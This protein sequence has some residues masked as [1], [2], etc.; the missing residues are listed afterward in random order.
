MDPEEFARLLD[1]YDSSFRNIAEGEVV[2]GT[3]LKVELDGA[4]I[5]L[6][7]EDAEDGRG[8]KLAL[9]R[10][11]QRIYEGLIR[12]ALDRDRAFLGCLSLAER[13]HLEALQ[14][15]RE[16]ERLCIKRYACHVTSHAPV[17]SMRELMA[18]PAFHDGERLAPGGEGPGQG[19]VG[20]E[21]VF[22]LEDAAWPI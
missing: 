8:V 22:E 16:I 2:K 5:V 12:A 17:Q 18:E 10:S 3:V 14:G 11:G 19:G 21:Q 4:R 1:S 9:G 20:D 15:R 6:R 7:K 13:R